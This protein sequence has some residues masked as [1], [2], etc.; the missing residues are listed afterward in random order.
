MWLQKEIQLAAQPR[1]FHLVTAE[2]LRELPEL[3]T[4]ISA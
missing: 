1:G 4:S 3:P 2:V